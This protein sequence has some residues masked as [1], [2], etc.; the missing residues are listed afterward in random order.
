MSQNFPA[1]RNSILQ[2]NVWK[3]ENLNCGFSSVAISIKC[4]QEIILPSSFSF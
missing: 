1:N 3:N 4:D 2:T